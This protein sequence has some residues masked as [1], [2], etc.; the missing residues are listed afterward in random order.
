MKA[1]T[2]RRILLH[3]PAGIITALSSLGVIAYTVWVFSG[4]ND[5]QIDNL[6]L[7]AGLIFLNLL[8]CA[9]GAMI[10]LQP[11]FGRTLRWAWFM[12][13]LGAL[14]HVLAEGTLLYIGLGSQADPVSRTANLFSVLYY[15]LTMIGLLI[16]PLVFV[17]RKERGILW[18]DLAIVIMFFAMVL[19]YFL[20]AAPI[21]SADQTTSQYF[22]IVYAVGDYL[23]LAAIIA[24]IQ[25]DLTRAARW[26]LG[27]MALAIISAAVAD[28]LFAY[29]ELMHIPYL[30]AYLNILWL[31]A[32][33]FQML[34]AARQ[35][36][37]GPDMLNDPPA[38]FS[39]FRHLFSLALPYLAIIIG[40]ALLAITIYANPVLN[41]RS[42]GL[43]VGAYSLVGLVLL[44]QYVVL[45]ENVRL[46]QT[47]R[48]IAWTD[49]LTGVYNRHFFHEMLPREIERAQRY[50]HQL[51][52]L[53]LD[54]DDFKK[55][56]DA[57]GHLRGDIALKNIARLF[58]NQLR[59]SDI[60][61][62]FGGDEFVVILPEAN[63]RRASA[64]AHRISDAVDAHSLEKSGL[65]VSIGVASFRPGLTPEQLLDEADKDM[66]HHKQIAKKEAVSAAAAY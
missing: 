5:L 23:I 11:D 1:D 38:R 45:R 49:S 64:I 35:I 13:S 52:V 22:A 60:I 25:R 61:A 28:S 32:A 63:R 47:M 43:L 53:L 7:K 3:T 54:I 39:P 51:S 10:V 58:S 42:A 31:S 56:N 17:P 59:S 9:F 16:F 34:A 19:W 50:H 27:F 65:S 30:M 8:V 57:H 46:Y 55:F 4:L 40:L 44:R 12:F 62:R 15:P 14:S 29:Y 26:I 21:L 6:I 48:R 37:S 18:L 2:S 36:A 24:L 41:A 66:Y 33:Q 20:L